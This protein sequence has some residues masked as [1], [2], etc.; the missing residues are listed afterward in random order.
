MRASGQITEV[1]SIAS[2]LTLNTAEKQSTLFN[3]HSV[4]VSGEV[5]RGPFYKLT[6][7]VGKYLKDPVLHPEKPLL[8]GLGDI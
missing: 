7:R 4:P 8:S 3:S 5:G 1:N 6:L 2:V